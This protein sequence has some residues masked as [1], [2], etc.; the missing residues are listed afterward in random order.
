MKGKPVMKPEEIVLGILSRNPPMQWRTLKGL[1]SM[2]GGL[3]SRQ[4]NNALAALLA[5][6]AVAKGEITV[7]VYSIKKEV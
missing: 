3:S 4:T 2:E 5:T 1:A 7:L 6:G